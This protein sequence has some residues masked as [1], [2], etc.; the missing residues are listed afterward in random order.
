MSRR[1][2]LA[3][4][5]IALA[6]TASTGVASAAVPP[7]KLALMPLPKTAYGDQ[8]ASF[9]LDRDESGV[10]DNARS[11]AD[12]SDPTDT[13]KSLALA[14]RVTGFSVTFAN[15]R[16]LSTPGK[17]VYVSSSVDL[18]RDARSASVGLVRSLQQAV[19]DDPSVGFKVLASERFVA[20]GLGDAAVGVRVKAKFGAAQLWVTGVEVQHG[21]LLASVGVM[22]TDAAPANATAIALARA[23][24][25]R[26]EG[27]L[28][29]E[30]KAPPAS[31]PGV[32]ETG[33]R[34][35]AP[36]AS[37]AGAALTSADVGGAAITRGEY[38][39]GQT[40]VAAY[41]REFDS[42]KV[43]RSRLMTVE[44]DVSLLSSESGSAAMLAGIRGVLDPRGTALKELLRRQ[45][46][47]SNGVKLDSVTVVRQ[48]AL[49][50]PSGEG[51]EVVARLTT[52]FGRFEQAWVFV[53]SGRLFGTLYLTSS[54][55]AS[56][57]EADVTRL[58][59]TLARR[60][61]RTCLHLTPAA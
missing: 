41:V 43:G 57:D 27:V 35:V 48:R 22:R 54:P 20:P 11:A 17:L 21:P 46:A 47:R 55:G 31:L 51:Y 59:T 3:L 14:G 30:V 60:M 2:A 45:F 61:H 9:G 28:A 6:L 15:L 34:P 13:G 52:L 38:V 37:I 50:L 32:N 42:A 7:E 53:S 16:L 39:S 56:L 24:F 18:Y 33:R 23:L 5:T 49:S 44:N 58:G 10:V 19:A 12:T 36:G 29:G 40:A 4:V 25:T 1:R 8:A 26:V